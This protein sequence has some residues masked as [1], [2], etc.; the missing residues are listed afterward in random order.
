[1]ETVR[2]GPTNE[3][4]ALAKEITACCACPR[5]VAWR[6][7]AAAAPPARHQGEAYWARPLPG[8]GDPEAKVLIVGLAPAAHGG[9]RTGRVFTG[10]RAGDFL[11]ASLFRTGFANQQASTGPGDGLALS[12][13]FITGTLRCAPPANRPL[14]DEQARCAHYL[15]RE[16]ALLSAVRVVVALGAIALRTVWRQ[17]TLGASGPLPRFTHGA[18]YA[19]ARPR[20]GSGARIAIASYHPSQRNVFTG[21]LTALML[22]AVF[23][24]ARQLSSD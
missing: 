21:R 14:P 12:G 10:D 22:D 3:L 13:A 11:F 15:E 9:N 16:L 8:F 5:L 18:E 2:P 6:E 24:R 7:A 19:L 4:A 1:M 17:G 23:A 20:R